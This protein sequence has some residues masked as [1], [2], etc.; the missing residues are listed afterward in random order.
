MARIAVIDDVPDVARLVKRILEE[1][2]HEVR[3]FTEETEALDFLRRQGPDLAVLD[4][5][6]QQMD[7]VELLREIR[8]FAPQTRVVVLT[9]YPTVEVRREVLQLGAYAFCVKPIDNDEL[10]E[11]VARALSAPTRPGAAS[12]P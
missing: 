12:R 6:L 1:K 10:A 3:A 4:L 7:G 9:G 8:R 2:G 11:T 5:H